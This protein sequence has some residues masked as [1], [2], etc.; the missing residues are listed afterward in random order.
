MDQAVIHKAGTLQL[1]V[2]W[3][4]RQSVRRRMADAATYLVLLVL[5]FGSLLPVAWMLGTSLKEPKAIF[6]FPPQWIPNPI[7]WHNYV[8]ALT[9]LPFGRYF[10]NTLFITVS[11]IAGTVITS[12]LTAYALARLRAPFKTALFLV[13]LSPMFLPSQVTMIPLFVFF[14]QLNWLDTYYPLIV[15][16]FFGGGAFNIFLLRQFFATIPLELDQAARIDGCNEFGILWRI[17]LPLS[18]PALATVAIFGFM[19]HWN[20]FLGP[21]IY[22]NSFD[23]LTVTLG[24]SRFRGEYGTTTWHLLMAASV[25]AV[26]PCIVIFFVAQEYFVQG[27]QMTGIKG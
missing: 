3:R 1:G 27:I 9:F 10:A 21:L 5:S 13:L 25:V 24:L 19:G 11:C 20:D 22:I 14:K 2:T 26:V 15:P 17:I 8:E 12:S 18:K 16:S 4:R 23:K 6:L 7:V